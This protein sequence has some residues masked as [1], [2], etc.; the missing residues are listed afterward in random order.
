MLIL[1]IFIVP[2]FALVLI[3]AIFA[4]GVAGVTSSRDDDHDELPI[5]QTN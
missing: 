3:G 1:Q 5:I 2:V 4:I